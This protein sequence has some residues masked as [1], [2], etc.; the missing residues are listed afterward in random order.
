[1]LLTVFKY[2]TPFKILKNGFLKQGQVL[3][4]KSFVSQ[5]SKSDSNNEIIPENKQEQS[6]L[7]KHDQWPINTIP[8]KKEQGITDVNSNKLDRAKSYKFDKLENKK[9]E[10]LYQSLRLNNPSNKASCDLEEN[11]EEP[12]II[13]RK[14]KKEIKAHLTQQIMKNSRKSKTIE[15]LHSEKYSHYLSRDLVI[16]G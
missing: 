2:E 7:E 16:G 14:I 4:K 5:N 3:I 10:I 8:Q 6:P 11:R 9:P 1:M 12:I 13:T 15:Y